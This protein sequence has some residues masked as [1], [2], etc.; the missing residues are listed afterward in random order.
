M[1]NNIKKYILKN[2]IPVLL[3]KIEEI[4]SV[5]LGIFVKTGAKHELKGEE[6][7]SHLLEHMMFK[8]TKT[9]TAKDISEIIDNEGGI[10]NAYTG[11][12]NT[13]YYV[14]MLSDSIGK[15]IEI[16]TDMFL[17]SVF[18]H[19]NLEK[20]KSVVIEEIN[21]Y[22]DIPEEIIHDQNAHMVID[23]VQGNI[24]LGTI[25]SVKELTREKLI[26][27]F[28]ETYIAKNIVIS[29]A[30]NFS[31]EE[32]YNLL[33]EGFGNIENK[34][35]SRSYTGNMCINSGKNIIKKDTNQVH[36][37]FN[38]LGSSLK[39]PQKYEI[40]ILS[41]ILAGNMSS[42]LFQKVR[43][44]KGLAYSIYSYTSS[45]EEGGLLTIYAGTT[46]KDYKKVIKMIE[47]EFKNIREKGITNYELE[48]TKKQFLSAVTFGLESTKGRMNRMANSYL[49]YEEVK[50][51]DL[52]LEEINKITI[53][54]IKI[55]A[56]KIFDKK[57]YSKT[58]LGD[59]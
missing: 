4:N 36:L 28:K 22:N 14:Q 11:K 43:E 3:D 46:K 51:L 35:C 30:G 13:V 50:D 41:N 6:G 7:I 19:E 16:L 21:M 27:Y 42:R 55:V 23:G 29:A 32:I 49:L 39:N 31:E 44:E 12:E 33:N 17:N 20:E 54:D 59:V 40:A 15:G 1:S 24:V 53:E 5:S 37:C 25:E 26:K 58:I 52:L 48:K 10:I 18:S 9:R 56:N 2:G 57:Y 45:Y 34:D 8:G 38:T 47:E